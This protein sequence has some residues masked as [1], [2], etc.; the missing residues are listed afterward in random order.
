MALSYNKAAQ[1]AAGKGPPTILSPSKDSASFMMC[2]GSYFQSAPDF[3]C[4]TSIRAN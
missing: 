3:P 2:C 4:V 1:Q